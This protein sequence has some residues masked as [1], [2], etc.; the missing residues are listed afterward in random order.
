MQLRFKKSRH[1]TKRRYSNDSSSG[2]DNAGLSRKPLNKDEDISAYEYEA[3]DK[4]SDPI[5]YIIKSTED[6]FS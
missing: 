5:M 2:S 4:E 3:V 1:V 6:A